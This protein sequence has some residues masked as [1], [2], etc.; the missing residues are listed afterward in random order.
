MPVRGSKKENREAMRAF[1][2][3]HMKLAFCRQAGAAGSNPESPCARAK[4]RSQ[5]MQPPASTSVH[6]SASA[7][8]PFTG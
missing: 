8:R 7:V 4:A 2:I 1:F 6:S 5:G 3:R